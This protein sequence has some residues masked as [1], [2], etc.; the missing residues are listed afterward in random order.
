MVENAIYIINGL[1]SGVALTVAG[2]SFFFWSK[3]TKAKE[4]HDKL[5]DNLHAK[6]VFKD[7]EHVQLSADYKQLKQDFQQLA[8]EHAETKE[9]N[10]KLAA[11][12]N[13]IAKDYHALKDKYEDLLTEHKEL[14]EKYKP[15]AALNPFERQAVEAVTNQSTLDEWMNGPKEV[16]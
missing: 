10:S 7:N 5:Y 13:S 14:Q 15:L 8:D 1:V 2:G 11:G 12:N 4:N 3:L 16:N 6:Y 9:N